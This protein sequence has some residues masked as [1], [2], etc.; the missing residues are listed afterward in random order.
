M[1]IALTIGMSYA[2]FDERT[3]YEFAK[4]VRAYERKRKEKAEWDTE[5]MKV[6]TYQTARLV[7]QFVWAKKIPEYDQV[8]KSDK[9]VEQTDAMM[10]AHVQAMNKAFG[11]LEIEKVGEE[12]DV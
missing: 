10:L 11:G 9:E 7:A 2:E 5:M 8:F 1:E 3:P 6:T 12:T 4:L